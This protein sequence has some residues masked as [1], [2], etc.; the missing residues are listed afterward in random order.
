M[1][2]LPEV[3]TIRRGLENKIIGL[4]IKEIKVVFPK[5]IQNTKGQ[6]FDFAQGL[7]GRNVL[8]VWRR[9]K[10]LGINLSG[11]LTIVFH[12][13]MTGQ[14]ILDDRG[15]RVIG[16]HPT[17]DMRDSMP[18]SSTIVIFEFEDPLRP[19]SLAKGGRSEASGGKL[20]F[21]DQ[22]RF[23]WVK[24][25]PTFEVEANDYEKLGKLGP[26]PL[27]ADF[28]W[29]KL[30]D[31]LLRHKKMP[32]KVAIMDQS[33]VAG[34]G[35]IYASESL[36]LARI[37]PRRKAESLSDG[38]FKK[39]HW[40]IIDSLETSIKHGGSTRAHFVNVEG[41]RGYFLD[42]AN[43]YGKTGRPCNGCK[44]KVERIEQ[45]GRGTFFCPNCQK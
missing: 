38:E 10:M 6:P 25:F 7:Q 40:G 31:N 4:T 23:G 1:P 13:K 24:L 29:E 18:N 20:Y 12:L 14:L 19:Q 16:G 44:G 27:T 15:E 43:V 37:D 42:F 41:S 11:N 32:I 34:V 26:E 30:K 33:V 8:E 45:A 5:S 2:E 39:L 36:F 22:R 17:P 21:N 35:N 3:E 28:T 9:A